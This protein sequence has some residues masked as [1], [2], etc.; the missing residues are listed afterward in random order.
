MLAPTWLQ[1]NARIGKGALTLA[2]AEG[3]AYRRAVGTVIGM[4][5]T[6]TVGQKA[7]TGHYIHENAAGKR[8][9]IQLPGKTSTGRNR[10][11]PLGL[12]TAADFA[13]LPLELAM[14]VV[15]DKDDP[16]GS[17]TKLLR[18]RLSAPLSSA[19]NVMANVDYRGDPLSGKDRFGRKITRTEGLL[20]QGTELWSATAP[21][22]IKAAL[23]YGRGKVNLEEALAEGL[24][25]PIRYHRPWTQRRSSRRRSRRG[26]RSGRRRR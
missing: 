6:A 8:F 24:E 19:I 21:Q 16:T 23:D 17:A 3:R 13:R 7:S 2:T 12:G 11:V 25:L 22:Q 26:R 18:N 4:Y 9:D 5:G 15:K 20:N 14:A 10:Y 1:S